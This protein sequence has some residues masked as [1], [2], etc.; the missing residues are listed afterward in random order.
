VGSFWDSPMR[1]ARRRL[2]DWYIPTLRKT[3]NPEGLRESFLTVWDEI[4][5][6]LPAPAEGFL[7][8][9]FHVENLMLLP[10]GEIGVIDFQ[11]ALRGPFAYDLG[12]LLED[13]RADVP[14]DIQTELLQGK[15]ESFMGWYRA[16]T[17]QFHMRLLGQCI[18]WAVRENKPQYMQFMPHL[19]H[20]VTKALAD[21]LLAPLKRWC[22]QE[23]LDF[24]SLK[25]FNPEEIRPFIP[26]DAL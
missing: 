15:D 24:T 3:T 17:T 12:N 20:Y 6:S 19:E 13:M 5:N 10:N 14:Q 26:D 4:E 9:D 23:G 22:A 25:D 7:H 2:T 1:R 21:P 11:E 8:I 16:L 18:R